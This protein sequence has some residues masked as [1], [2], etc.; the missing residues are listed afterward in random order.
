MS[1]DWRGYLNLAVRLGESADEASQRSAISRAYY[2]AF[3]CACGYVERVFSVRLTENGKAHK[4]VWL[5]LS[6]GSDDEQLAGNKGANL[7]ES[8]RVADYKREG[9]KF[10][11]DMESALE[12]ARMIVGA[13]SIARTTR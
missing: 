9:L 8:R 11:D 3:H 12:D 6:E 7:R 5:K 13:L 1:F 4:L 10:P 2:A